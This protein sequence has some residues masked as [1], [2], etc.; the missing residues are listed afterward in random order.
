LLIIAAVEAV[1]LITLVVTWI[2]PVIISF[3]G[4]VALWEVV[5]GY[6]GFF[7][8][9]CA[10]IAIGLFISSLTDSQAVAAISTFG[11]ILI[12]QILGGNLIYL[13]SNV[14]A[15]MIFAGIL[16]LLAAILVRST[17]KNIY[18]GIITMLLGAAIMAAVYF[19]NPNLYSG[20]VIRFFRW[21]LLTGRY[22]EFT[23]GV[24]SFSSVVYYI[25]FTAFFLFLTVRIID[26]KRWS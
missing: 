9:G 14:Q 10:Y 4:S 18:A 11:A 24:V 3:F 5:G 25:S 13:P 17:T 2:Y 21:F 12:L 19:I 23:R 1:F 8:L 22:V 7:L 15:S 16:V 20:F 6:I 26:K